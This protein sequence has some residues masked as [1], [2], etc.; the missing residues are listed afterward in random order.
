MTS[1][2]WVTGR[3]NLRS[4]VKVKVAGKENVKI[5]IR[6]YLREKWIDLR[7]TKT[8]I[9]LSSFYNAHIVE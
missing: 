8:K 6:A 7:Q 5:V 3:A 1:L 9:V 4:K 2:H